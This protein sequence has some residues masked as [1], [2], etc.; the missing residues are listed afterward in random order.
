LYIG[1][2]RRYPGRGSKGKPLIG[3]GEAYRDIIE[4]SAELP[5]EAPEID[6]AGTADEQLRLYQQLGEQVIR[7]GRA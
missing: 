4:R 3:E 7:E 2:R 1:S 6:A 5:E